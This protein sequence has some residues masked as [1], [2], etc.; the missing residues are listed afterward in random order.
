MTKEEIKALIATAIAGQ[1]TNVDGGGQLP[2][3]LNAIV[4]AIPEAGFPE[5]KYDVENAP[6]EIEDTGFAEFL[7][8]SVD[9]L[10]EFFKEPTIRLGR[11]TLTRVFYEEKKDEGLYRTIWGGSD[12]DTGYTFQAFLA[13]KNVVTLTIAV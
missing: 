2:N 3:I 13:N 10:P 8:I 1:G 12:S 5:P 9:E 11:Y 6:D 7:G 4:D